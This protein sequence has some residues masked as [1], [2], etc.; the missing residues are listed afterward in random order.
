MTDL[1]RR[2][3][4]NPNRPILLLLSGNDY[5]AKEFLEYAKTSDDWSGAFHQPLLQRH[6]LA[7]ADHTCSTTAWRKMVEV[8]VLEWLMRAL[9]SSKA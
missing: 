7:E 6:D 5:T 8:R 9:P 3:W 2:A 4:K 1:S